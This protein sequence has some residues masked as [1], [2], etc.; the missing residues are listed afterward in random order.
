MKLVRLAKLT[1]TS[2]LARD[3]LMWASHPFTVFC[4]SAMDPC[5]IHTHTYTH[6]AAPHPHCGG[7]EDRGLTVSPYL[8]LRHEY[9][10][11]R[12]K[13]RYKYIQHKDKQVPL[14]TPATRGK[15]PCSKE[16]DFFG[17]PSTRILPRQ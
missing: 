5:T 12:D 14:S 16:V 15:N 8:S 2:E 9:K 10:T 4:S 13:Y 11:I 7:R 1:H 3:V 6:T 17:S